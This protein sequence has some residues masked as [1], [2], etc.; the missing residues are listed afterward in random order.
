MAQFPI[1]RLTRAGHELSGMSQG[2]GKL[3]FVRAELGDGQIGEEESVE[4][5]T[6]LKHQV[7]QL[8]LQGYLNEENG[9]ARLRFVVE[10]SSLTAGFFNREIGVFAKMEGGEEQ[11][12]AYT[13]A[14]NYADYIPSKETPIDGEII[15]LHIIIGNAS[16]VTIVT[17]NSVYATQ[18]DLEEHNKAPD[19]HA[20]LRALISNAGIAILQRSRSYQVGDI[21]YHKALP[22]WARLECVKAG[23]TASTEP[24]EMRQVS[25]GKLITDGGV[26]WIVDDV[27][28]GARV[29][30]I[31]LR[32]T[33]REGYIKAN[34][35]TVKASEYP[36]LL[37]WAQEAG[38]AVTAGQYAQDCSKYVYDA[39]QDKLTLPNM[40]GRV[41]Q[42]GETV[43]SVEAGL[44]QHTHKLNG[45]VGTSAQKEISSGGFSV[46]DVATSDT[47]AGANNP[48]YGRSDT[49]QPPALHL[50]AQ[51][52][53]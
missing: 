34:G 53:Y 20:D 13:N 41:L 19:A 46:V 2:G 3:I 7:M 50:I 15:D 21:A 18:A 37:A 12:Y 32:P 52:K 40:T 35:A 1:L 6:A 44:P 49:V 8:P 33:L 23:T 4:N 5:L 26:T 29:G 51:I 25:A 30:D 9:K 47:S 42:G 36:R 31:I 14:G 16:N 17:K 45:W 22:S 28:D 43:K 39:A 24:A 27:R 10:N 11:L 48:I 38:M